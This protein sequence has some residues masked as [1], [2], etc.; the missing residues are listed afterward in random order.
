M[1]NV[2]GDLAQPEHQ[3][4]DARQHGV[5][6]AGEPV[7][8]V[9]C[10][11]ARDTARQVAGH[12]GAAGARHGIDAAQ[13]VAAEQQPAAETQQGNADHA[14]EQDATHPL[15]VRALLLDVASHDQ[16]AAVRQRPLRPGRQPLGRDA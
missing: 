12:D 5:E 16:D 2:V 7:E 9:A 10:P 13:D 1:G 14:A 15:D 3:P 4:L 6:A 8:L 11:T